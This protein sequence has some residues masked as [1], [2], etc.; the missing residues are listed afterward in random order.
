MMYLPLQTA[1]DDRELEATESIGAKPEP[2]GGGGGG[3]GGGGRRRQRQGGAQAE[4]EEGQDALEVVLEPLLAVVVVVVKGKGGAAVGFGG[5]GK[6]RRAAGGDGSRCF[7]TRLLG[8]RQKG[9]PRLKILHE[10]ECYR[11]FT[12]SGTMVREHPL[13][14][15][16]KVSGFLTPSP[17]SAI[18]TDLNYKIHAASLT[19]SAFP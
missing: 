17:L 18:G 8:G 13:M 19:T 11:L 5:V 16:A 10:S 6:V 4:K 7:A 1:V 14:T 15:S 9:T 2:G 12:E 3:E